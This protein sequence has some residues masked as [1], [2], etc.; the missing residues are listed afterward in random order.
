MNDSG[1]A[2]AGIRRALGFCLLDIRRNGRRVGQ[3]D[4]RA[5]DVRHYLQQIPAS[6]IIADQD[7]MYLIRM[8]GELPPPP[9]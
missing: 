4:A 3:L 9:N 2:A 6:N 7:G 1:A 5:L 8:D